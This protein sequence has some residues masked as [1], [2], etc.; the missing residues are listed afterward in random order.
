MQFDY[1]PPKH[2]IPGTAK[3]LRLDAGD[4]NPGVWVWQPHDVVWEANPDQ[5]ATL[6]ADGFERVE[7]REGDYQSLLL[8]SGQFAPTVSIYVQ[9]ATELEIW[10]SRADIE[11]TKKIPVILGMSFAAM[12]LSDPVHDNGTPILH[13]DFAETLPHKTFGIIGQVHLDK[14]YHSYHVTKLGPAAKEIQEKMSAA[15][16]SIVGDGGW[17]PFDDDMA[18]LTRANAWEP[19]IKRLRQAVRENA[20]NP[21]I[22]ASFEANLIALENDYTIFKGWQARIQK[23]GDD[24]HEWAVKWE[25]IHAMAVDLAGMYA[26]H[27]QKQVQAQHHMR[28]KAP[29]VSD[30]VKHR[31]E[32]G[33]GMLFAPLSFPMRGVMLATQTTKKW[34][35][36]PGTPDRYHNLPGTVAGDYVQTSLAPPKNTNLA[37]LTPETIAQEIGKILDR[38]GA[39]EGDVILAI[40][41]QALVSETLPDGSFWINPETILAYRGV[42][43]NMKKEGGILR[44]AGHHGTPRQAVISAFERAMYL[45]VRVR[46]TEKGRRPKEI[47]SHLLLEL[48][49]EIQPALVPGAKEGL[50]AWRV[51][52][53]TWFDEYNLKMSKHFGWLLQK[54]LSYDPEHQAWEKYLGRYFT[55]HLQIAAQG[56]QKTIERKIRTLVEGCGIDIDK[57]HPQRAFDFFKRAMITLEADEVIS[58]WSYKDTG[59]HESPPR[60]TKGWLDPWLDMVVHIT[61][62][63]RI[64]NHGVQGMIDRIQE[65]KQIEASAPAQLDTAVRNGQEVRKRGRPRKPPIPSSSKHPRGRPRKG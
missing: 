16:D 55:V 53:G 18:E 12:G 22:R 42:K 29:H 2:P 65:R 7:L 60:T 26:E 4:M 21:E 49:R 61:C 32:E 37:N 15:I 5:L 10:A 20:A 17:P 8:L 43:P 27:H 1:T 9:G 6:R 48:E 58:A 54:V 36:K 45:Y 59:T 62:S 52:P 11:R 51:K 46:Q 31:D 3:W 14:G 35:G 63:S 24:R 25:E 64:L 44:T 34:L 28:V 19:A 57:R 56:G 50:I 33:M 38:I 23:R 41:A 30:A 13:M 47:Q 39:L 40:M